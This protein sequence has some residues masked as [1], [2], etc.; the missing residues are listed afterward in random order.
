MG[1]Y[2]A[3]Q[4]II[5]IPLNSLHALSHEVC[6]SLANISAYVQLLQLENVLDKAKADRITTEV[7]RINNMVNDFSRLSKPLS[8]KFVRLSL[9]E[10]LNDTVRIIFL[11]AAISKV[12]IKTFFDENIYAKVDKTLLQQVMINIIDNATQSWNLEGRLV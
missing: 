1:K 3:D 5:D 9:K 2:L 10:L 12:E 8:P 11:K 7:S 6:N 4:T